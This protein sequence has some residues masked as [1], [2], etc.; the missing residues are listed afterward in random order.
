MQVLL[1]QLKEALDS[2]K[3]EQIHRM[4]SYF[5]GEELKIL[6]K[7]CSSR[8]VEP[9]ELIFEAGDDAHEIYIVLS[10]EILC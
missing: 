9:Y 5:D 4:T 6:Q 3:Y 1:S 2:R 7:V 8:T 10:G